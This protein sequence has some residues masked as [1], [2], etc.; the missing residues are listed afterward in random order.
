MP[1]DFSRV[2][3]FMSGEG[4]RPLVKKQIVEYSEVA[5]SETP[6]PVGF[7]PLSLLEHRTGTLLVGDRLIGTPSEPER[8]VTGALR[9]VEAIASAL[10][11]DKEDER[12]VDE[13][14]AKRAA[15]LS[16]RPLR[17]REGEHR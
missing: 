10:P 9:Y 2:I 7:R 11:L 3:G 15:K 12:I 13:L 5:S 17:R 6:L 4:V 16:T 8:L 14:M 1:S